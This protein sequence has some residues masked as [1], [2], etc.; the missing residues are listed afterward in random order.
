MPIQTYLI[1]AFSFYAASAMGANTILRSLI[2][3][4]LPLCG[5]DMYEALGVGPGN[6]LLGGIAIALIPIPF[7]FERYVLRGFI[8]RE[9][10]P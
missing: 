7:L 4:L 2:G 8:K 5:V 1:D 9:S 6:S 3:A 10:L